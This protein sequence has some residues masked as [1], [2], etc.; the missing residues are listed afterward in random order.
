MPRKILNI[1]YFSAVVLLAFL[2]IP[3][4]EVVITLVKGSSYE[5]LIKNFKGVEA[6]GFF[7]GLL[8]I[9]I[10]A[11]LYAGVRLSDEA[12][13]EKLAAWQWLRL[14]SGLYLAIFLSVHLAA[15]YLARFILKLE[16]GFYSGAAGMNTYPLQIAFLIYAALLTV[17]FGAKYTS[18]SY[19]RQITSQ[20]V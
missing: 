19:R 7:E 17:F 11:Q 5:M 12:Y 6:G 14:F 1:Q 18:H 20:N 15:V 10:V 16:T 8:F 4:P 2:S 9:A 3:V 13:R